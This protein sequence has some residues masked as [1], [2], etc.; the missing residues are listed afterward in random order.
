MTDILAPVFEW[1]RA[2]GDDIV[3]FHRGLVSH[4]AVGPDNGGQGETA[5]VEWLAG[6]LASF[7][8]RDLARFDSPDPR[9]SSGTRPN[10]VVRL[11]GRRPRPA[12]HVLC[13]TDVV[14]PG[15]LDF[16]EGDPFAMRVE[17][18]RLIAR[19]T[20]DNGQGLTSTV[21]ALR[22]LLQAGM[23]P[24]TDVFL[25][26]V[27]DEETG[28]RHGIEHLLEAAPEL[29]HP[30]DLV[31]VPDFGLPDGAAIEVAEKSTL[32][33]RAHVRGR[34]VHASLPDHGVNANRAAAYLTTRLDETLAARFAETDERFEPA[35]STFEPTK[36]EANVPN[37]NTIPGEETL[38]FDCRI[39]PSADLREVQR[40]I[41][42]V[43][44][45]VERDFGVTIEGTFPSVVP[46]AP[47]TPDD[48]PVVRALERALQDLRGVRA[49]TIGIG[50]GTVAAAFRRRGIPAAVWATMDDT[51]HQPNEYASLGNLVADAEVLAHVFLQER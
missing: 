16:W 19:G 23:T 34:Q 17:G 29:I 12:V 25:L 50:G 46:A 28:N 32:W 20:E 13:H 11:R 35:R 7:G 51:G 42:D 3:D 33:F 44:A 49:R 18:G 9:V 22:A 47:P 41:A 6:R 2:S 10:L 39:L 21:F 27:A 1:L 5:K 36:R 43:A 24:A 4:P 15:D 48:A 38:F 26:L 45:S 8:L 30:G 40:V 31:I 14:P 37:V